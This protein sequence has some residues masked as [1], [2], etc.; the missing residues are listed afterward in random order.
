MTA[1]VIIPTYNRAAV[2]RRA[3]ESVF[4]QTRRAD[5]VIVVDDGSTDGTEELVRRHFPEVDY[6]RQENAGVSAARNRGIA[7]AQC[8]WIAFLDSDDEWR[9]GKL[10]RQLDKMRQ[11]PMYHIS[12]T[13][14]TW[15]RNGRRVN[16]GKRH[17]KSG[18][19]IFKRC[20]PLCVISPSSVVVRHALFDEVGGFD[21]E[22]PVCEDY[23]MW[24]RICARHPVLFLDEPLVVKHGGHADQLSKRFWGMDRFRIRAIEKILSHGNLA[25]DLREAAVRALKQKIDVYLKGASR[26]G[27]A[28]EVE[29]YT[30]LRSKHCFVDP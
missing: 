25:P 5:Q 19:W 14:E 9:P 13:N 21:E 10:E 30:A 23:D 12:H 24:L 18:G 7:E 2:L 1:S 16:E 3:L 28:D 4:A 20:L 26:R 11:H 29:K 15:I 22:L 6:V 27:K 8:D 17:A